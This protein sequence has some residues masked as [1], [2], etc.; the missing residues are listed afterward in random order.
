M[1]S[2]DLI[3]TNLDR[4]EPASSEVQFALVIARMIDSVRNSPEHM[5]QAVYDLARYKLQE[6]FT[7]ADAKDIKRT[8]QALESAI[9][10]VEEFSR[11]HPSIPPAPTPPPQIGNPD[12]ATP[13]LR[14]LPLPEFFS[15]ARRPRLE[16]GLESDID[17]L[18]PTHLPWPHLKR[19]AA[20][21][22]ILVAILVIVQQR[23]RLTSLAQSLSRLDSQ[24]DM[25]KQS[26]PVSSRPTSSA[27]NQWMARTHGSFEMSHSRFER[28]PSM[29]ILKC[30][31]STAKIR[32]W[33]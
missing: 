15:Q 26:A 17:D 5:R 4:L 22:D 31:N 9:R 10:G 23:E 29:T 11:Q 18:K 13:A 21:I 33:S 30:T 32:H 8:Q 24:A 20:L 28:P 27:R 6:Q 7:Y 1:N 19:A 25:K 14:K 3:P 16:M 12:V 2:G